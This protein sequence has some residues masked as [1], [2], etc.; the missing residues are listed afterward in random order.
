M[1]TGLEFKQLFSLNT[2]RLSSRWPNPRV[3][4]SANQFESTLALLNTARHQNLSCGCKGW[5]N[6]S[7]GRVIGIG[8]TSTRRSFNT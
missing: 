8:A 4:A 2:I 3:A 5:L 1:L 7:A 6:E